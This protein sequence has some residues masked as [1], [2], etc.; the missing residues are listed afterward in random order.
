MINKVYNN[1]IY[2]G[3]ILTKQTSNNVTDLII[4]S[5]YKFRICKI[6]KT[7]LTRKSIQMKTIPET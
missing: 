6:C 2:Y 7:D 4:M 5:V 3:I 1:N